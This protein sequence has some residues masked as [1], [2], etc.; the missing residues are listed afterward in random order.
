VSSGSSAR[1]SR[2][3]ACAALGLALAAAYWAAADALP[4]SFLADEVG[5]DGLP[6]ALAA[7]LAAFSI[8]IGLRHRGEPVEPKNH[9]R[10]LGIAVLGFGYVAIVPFAGYIVSIAL[11]AAAAAL[12]YGAPRRSELAIFALGTAALLYAVFRVLLGIR[13]P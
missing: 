12:L 13:M 3:L 6:K 1:R 2:E 9:L 5:A 4:T 11:L 10:A 7:L 8:L